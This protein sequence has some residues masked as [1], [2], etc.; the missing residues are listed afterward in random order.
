VTQQQTPDP[1][2]PGGASSTP[3]GSTAPETSQPASA[4]TP[5]TRA[6]TTVPGAS[7]LVYADVPNRVIALIIDAILL[8]I[9]TAVVTA[10]VYGIVGQPVAFNLQ[11]GFSFNAVPLLIGAI[12]SLAISAAYYIFTWTSLRASPGMKVLGMQVGNFPD[13]ATLTQQQAVRRWAA[14]WGVPSIGQVVYVAPTIG[15][16]LGLLTFVYMIYLL[17]TTAQSPTKQGF[18]DKFAN[19]VVVKA[20]RAV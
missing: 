12:V 5:S 20:A 18:H 19:S 11:T 15:A 7:G 3:Q 13:G 9:I 16:I 17:Y 1:G 2:Y 8:A 14:L 6:E 4:W 10:V